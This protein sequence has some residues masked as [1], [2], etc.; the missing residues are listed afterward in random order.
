MNKQIT[1]LDGAVGTSL[2]EK[3]DNKVPVWRY[4]I[5]NPDIVRELL[6]EYV[7]AGSEIILANTF[8]ANRP[9]MHGTDYNVEQIVTRAMEIAH[10]TIAGRAKTALAIGP[11]T[12]LLKPF[13]DISPEDAA[14]YFDEQISAGAKGKPDV[15]F[16]QTFID[17][18]MMKIAA[19]AARKHDI[20]LFCTMSFTKSSPKKGPRT[21]MGNSVE[22]IINGLEPFH[23]DGIGM[24][25]SMGP[26]TALPVIEEFSRH[27]DIP[28]IFKP[29]AGKPTLEGGSQFDYNVFAGEVSKAASIPGVK[30]I[31][32]C[33]GSNARYIKA[34]KAKLE[35]EA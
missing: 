27:T 22:D 2:W 20:P 10:E 32:G 29:N 12:G 30:Y 23:V 35:S 1:L 6:N 14:D 17:L 4:N 33:C 19:R 15:I 11:L 31:G 16:L 5:E 24:N 7:E 34:L 9:S 25:C 3:T 26:E 18:E 21:M 13:G 28:L 8:S